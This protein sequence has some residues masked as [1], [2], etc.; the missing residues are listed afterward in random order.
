MVRPVK[1]GHLIRVV[2]IGHDLLPAIPV[3]ALAT[4]SAVR[5]PHVF[6]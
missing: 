5:V 3:T 4:P 2:K 1:V 6:E